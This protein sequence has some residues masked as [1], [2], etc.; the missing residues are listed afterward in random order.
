MEN[1]IKT[2][3]RKDGTGQSPGV[4][5]GNPDSSK[6][7][8]ESLV[9][10]TMKGDIAYAIKNQNE[11]LVS[12]ALAEEKKR[13]AQRA[14]IQTIDAGAAQTTETPA[15]KRIGRVLVVGIIILILAGL[16]LAYKFLL[17]KLDTI[18]LPSI[19]L[20][21]F[22]NTSTEPVSVA[23]VVPRIALAASLIP[24]HFERRFII[25]KETPEKIFSDIAE[26]RTTSG[27]PGKIKNLYFA[28]DITSTDDIQK[29]VAIS[30]NSMFT[31]A[32]VSVP[33]ILTRSLEAQF[34]AGLLNEESSVLAT[35]FLVLRVSDYD[36][37]FAGMLE[38]ERSLPLL[39]A[40]IFGNDI[41]VGISSNP[42]TRDIVLLGRDARILE[43]AP[44]VVIAYVFANKQTIVIAGSQTAL[45]YII[46]LVK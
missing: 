10:R 36:T 3:S 41:T 15:P 24:A 43:I 2:T 14:E 13:A 9:I 17:P 21:S 28:E 32:G 42:R 35:P 30:A 7:T 46:P 26:E 34:M 22:V 29:T 4:Y 23:P 45:E 11:T 44:N 27:S 1:N 25:N 12:I 20:P 6:T 18:S 37:G 16:G 8:P 31:L 39:V 5:G 40:T 33:E 19:S 38:L